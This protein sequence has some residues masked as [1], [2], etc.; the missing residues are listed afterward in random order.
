MAID[1][2]EL[3]TELDKNPEIVQVAQEALTK[4]GY[5]IRDKAADTTFMDNY[6]KDVIEKELPAKLSEAYN[7][8]DQDIETITGLKK[9]STEK[10]HEYLKR[11]TSTVLSGLKEKITGYEKTIADKGDPTGEMRKKIEAA[12]DIARKAIA[13]KDTVV[14]D[15]T[16]KTEFQNRKAIVD[17]AYAELSKTFV[18]TLPF[19]FDRGSKQ[20]LDDVLKA[21]ILED[22]VLY[23]SDGNG[24]KKKDA[25]FNPIK[26]EDVLKAEFKEV[27]DTKR[28]QHGG[29][30]GNGGKGTPGD[31][32]PKAITKDTFVLP[33]TAKTQIDVMDAMIAMGLPRGD[34]FNEIYEKFAK[35]IEKV[36]ENGKTIR[37]QVGTALP[38]R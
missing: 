5:V 17:S 2:A 37:K 1:K 31:I 27:I 33:A 8:F 16:A 10:S 3:A 30:S 21:T 18:K 26:V 19:G 11:S 32:D 9:E 24:N 7:R 4:K 13:E 36:T 23:I 15:M 28:T 34:N 29:G 20:I 25:S 22:G 38:L 14:K 6:K 35:G 12:E